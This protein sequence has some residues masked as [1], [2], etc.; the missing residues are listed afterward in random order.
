[1]A[2]DPGS[3]GVVI[4]FS[5]LAFEVFVAMFAIV[6][7]TSV[8]LRNFH[9]NKMLHAKDKL[10]LALNVSCAIFTIMMTYSEF[11]N[12]QPDLAKI[13][14]WRP[15]FTVVIVYSICSCSWLSAL[16]CFFYCIK[17]V[18]FK[19]LFIPW[20][21][22][23][24][25]SI[26]PGQIVVV[27]LMSLGISLLHLLPYRMAQVSSINSSYI[28]PTNATTEHTTA[29]GYVSLV[30]LII[31][32]LP[33]VSSAVTIIPTTVFLKIH[34]NKMKENTRSIKVQLYERLVQ[35]M[36]RFLLHYSAFY[37]VLLLYY[38]SFFAPYSLGYWINIILLF[39]FIPATFILQILE[40]PDLRTPWKEMTSY[41]T[42]YRQPNTH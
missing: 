6:F 26:V 3:P 15:L 2:M 10:Q 39:S 19:W 11:S 21:K 42:H 4:G 32:C 35:K 27:E 7:I 25:S 20:I 33:L 22:M 31:I 38:F 13:S 30:F 8:I 5:V 9:R 17:I 24:I 23:K 34:M 16:L 1:M 41:F 29:S 28:P 12:M 37:V 18:H 40:N 14:A 36:I